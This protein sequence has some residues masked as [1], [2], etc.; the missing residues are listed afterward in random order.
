MHFP[1]LG[2]ASGRNTIVIQLHARKA[3][4]RS[5]EVLPTQSPQLE[6][7]SPDNCETGSQPHSQKNLLFLERPIP[8]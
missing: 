6:R 4:R 2:Q 1:Y 7:T 8:A 3:K 5:A